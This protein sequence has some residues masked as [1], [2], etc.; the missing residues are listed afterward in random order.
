MPR[1]N[2]HTPRVFSRQ[3]CVARRQRLTFVR[4]AASS[5][6]ED[7]A[8]GSAEGTAETRDASTFDDAAVDIPHPYEDSDTA[9]SAGHLITGEHPDAAAA[10]ASDAQTKNRRVAVDP[11]YGASV[12]VA[13]SA[14]APPPRRMTPF[15]DA[16]L[17]AGLVSTIVLAA[18]G[19]KRLMTFLDGVPDLPEE[20]RLRRAASFCDEQTRRLGEEGSEVSGG[21]RS[22][23]ASKDDELKRLA[24]IKRDIQKKMK[25][26][27]DAETRRLEWNRRLR[28][29]DERGSPVNRK[30]GSHP[31]DPSLAAFAS[32][33]ATETSATGR[34]GETDGQRVTGAPPGRDANGFDASG[35]GAGVAR[36]RSGGA[37]A[38][39]EAFAEKKPAPPG[40]G[41]RWV[42][43]TEYLQSA[44]EKTAEGFSNAEGLAPSASSTVPEPATEPV[45]GPAPS[46][47]T[48]PR[49]PRG[50][51]RA[52][53]PE[54]AAA[55]ASK[56]EKPPGAPRI[57]GRHPEP[58]D[59]AKPFVR[60]R[61]SEPRE[62]RSAGRASSSESRVVRK[63]KGTKAGGKITHPD[64]VFDGGDDFRS[65]PGMTPEKERAVAFEIAQLEQMYGDDRSI[66]AEELDAMCVEVIEKYDLSKGK[67]ARDELYDPEEDDGGSGAT[68]K[69]EGRAASAWKDDPFYWRRS[70]VIFPI[71][72]AD[73][74]TETTRVMTM[75]MTHPGLPAY[76]PGAKKGAP[77]RKPEPKEH[78][79][80][81]ESKS[82]AERFV[83]FMRSTRAK[84]EG[85]CTTRPFP[86]SV[87]EEIATSDGLL[88]TVIG[89]GRVNLDAGRRDVDVLSDIREIGGEQ[90]LWEFA[91]WTRKEL[92]EMRKPPPPTVSY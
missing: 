49:D 22:G 14:E 18:L 78:A 5:R 11:M 89:E 13:T 77:N 71:F 80:A 72:E 41:A 92:E 15:Q 48:E 24:T 87:F 53:R 30:P 26:F 83:W 3:K 52:P 27:Q 47:R 2:V 19:V 79:V 35:F 50:A 60:K 32:F 39:D 58:L 85:I 86:P 17:N 29:L 66:S 74:R 12:G 57:S 76:L 28:R 43:A 81:F 7:I 56:T 75:T 9:T 38:D 40:N 69:P 70:K 90:S 73:P 31:E 88:V 67:F 61:L 63:G 20:E 25:K 91:Q 33:Q 4:R 84:D 64:A 37:A 6:D 10:D 68:A 45:P 82:D 46:D 36:S 16:V 54:H 34:S 23:G 44:V 62:E 1:R 55:A 21:E 65:A 42:K 51:A 8:D 59:P